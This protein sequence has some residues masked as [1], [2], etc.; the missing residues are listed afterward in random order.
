MFVLVTPDILKMEATAKVLDTFLL[1]PFPLER[2]ALSSLENLYYQHTLSKKEMNVGL[3]TMAIM[4][5]LYSIN[6]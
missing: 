4:T 5:P 3:K 2:K 1:E 6:I